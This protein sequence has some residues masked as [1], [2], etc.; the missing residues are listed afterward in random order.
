MDGSYDRRRTP[1]RSDVAI[2]REAEP[3]RRRMLV[4]GAAAAGITAT[5]AV[6]AVTGWN[7]DHPWQA[8]VPRVAVPFALTGVG[9]TSR[10]PWLARAATSTVA[11]PAL[12]RITIG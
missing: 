4:A 11:S 2:T 6:T 5:V 12:S 3:P 10:L 7:R 8:T 9:P 1:P